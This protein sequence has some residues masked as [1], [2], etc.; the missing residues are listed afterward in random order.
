MSSEIHVWHD[1]TSDKEGWIVSREK[2]ESSNTLDICASRAEAIEIA[3][4]IGETSGEKVSEV[5]D[6]GEKKPL[7]R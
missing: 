6:G 2:G 5:L 3:I 7:T 4:N 1:T